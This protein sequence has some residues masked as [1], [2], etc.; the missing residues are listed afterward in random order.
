MSRALRFLT[1][2]TL[3]L[4]GCISPEVAQLR[5]YFKE[6]AWHQNNIGAMV[7]QMNEVQGLPLENRAKAYGELAELSA[8]QITLLEKIE[9]PPP[10]QAYHREIVSLYQA[11]SDFNRAAQGLIGKHGPEAESLVAQRDQAQKAYSSSMAAL[12]V[13][14]QKLGDQYGLSFE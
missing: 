9:V 4:A 10:A 12:E 6:V 14:E 3:L 8:Y 11:Y 1:L 5:Q 7:K 13:E 2:I